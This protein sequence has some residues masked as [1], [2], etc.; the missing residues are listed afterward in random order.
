M[1]VFTPKKTSYDDENCTYSP[2]STS[3]KNVMFATHNCSSTMKNVH[4]LKLLIDCIVLLV[5][6][7]IFIDLLVK[8][9]IVIFDKRRMG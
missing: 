7:R 8:I 1:P 2:V 6:K 3:V 4:K 9:E 5:Q